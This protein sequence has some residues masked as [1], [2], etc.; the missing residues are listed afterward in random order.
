MKLLSICMPHAF[1]FHP[2]LGAVAISALSTFLLP[3]RS[4]AAIHHTIATLSTTVPASTTAASAA[5]TAS[6]ETCKN[7]SP[8]AGDAA[9]EDVDTPRSGAVAAAI[10]SRAHI[11]HVLGLSHPVVLGIRHWCVIHHE[12]YFPKT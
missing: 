10:E 7:A 6:I 1:S 9:S 3:D 5:I 11:V 2:S 12:G 8:A 4:I